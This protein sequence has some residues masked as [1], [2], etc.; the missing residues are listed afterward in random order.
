M[1]VR[2]RQA[3]GDGGRFQRHGVQIRVEDRLDGAISDGAGRDGA[4]TR[5]FKADGVV[6]AAQREQPE[7]RAIA[8]LGMRQPAQ[9]AFDE[10]TGRGPVARAP[11][12]QARR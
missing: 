11:R 2:R 10:L 9:Q 3:R 4:R 12:D 8:L 7:T 6:A 1:R 5:R